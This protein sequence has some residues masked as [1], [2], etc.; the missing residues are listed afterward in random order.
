[1]SHDQTGELANIRVLVEIERAR[2]ESQKQIAAMQVGATAAAAR[3]KLK[4]QMEAEGVR[5]GIDAAKHRAQMSM[6]QRQRDN[7]PTNKVKN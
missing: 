5:M 2:I 7:R 3:D 1:M 4:Q 6:Q